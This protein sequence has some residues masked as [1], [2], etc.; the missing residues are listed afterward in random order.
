MIRFNVYLP[1]E[2]V[3]ELRKIANGRPLAELIRQAL[4]EFVRR[5]KR[6]G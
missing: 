1:P 4:T 5:Q 3:E 2:L 6:R